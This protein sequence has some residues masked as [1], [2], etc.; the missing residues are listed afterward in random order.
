MLVVK[1]G[2]IALSLSNQ[3]ELVLAGCLACNLHPVSLTAEALADI[4]SCVLLSDC[5]A[6]EMLLTGHS[7]R[8]IDST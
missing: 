1:V 2:S 8:R 6:A 5:P 4:P 3:I 7:T